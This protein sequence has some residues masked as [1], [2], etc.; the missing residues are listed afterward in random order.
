MVAE[1]FLVNILADIVQV[2]D[3]RDIKTSNLGKNK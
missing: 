1:Y 2:S 3:Y